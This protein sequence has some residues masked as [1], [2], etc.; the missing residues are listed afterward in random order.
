MPLAFGKLR[1]RASPGRTGKD[2]CRLVRNTIQADN[3]AEAPGRRG[4]VPRRTQSQVPVEIAAVATRRRHSDLLSATT[5][6]GDDV[7]KPRK[8]AR[9]TLGETVIGPAVRVADE[10]TADEGTGG[11]TQRRRSAVR[12]DVEALAEKVKN[13]K[14]AAIEQKETTATAASSR[15]SIAKNGSVSAVASQSETTDRGQAESEVRST[16]TR[17]SV[18]KKTTGAVMETESK[19]GSDEC[20]EER[21]S[22]TVAESESRSRSTR[23]RKSVNEETLPSTRERKTTSNGKQKTKEL[24]T[25]KRNESAPLSRTSKRMTE[26]KTIA[27]AHSTEQRLS[28][29]EV[30]D[31][32]PRSSRGRRSVVEKPVVAEKQAKDTRRTAGGRKSVA[33]EVTEPKKL[34]TISERESPVS[35]DVDRK[36]PKNRSSRTAVG[37]QSES[38]TRSTRRRKTVDVKPPTPAK[39]KDC[40][41]MPAGGTK[42]VVVD[43]SES[44]TRSKRK[45]SGR[46]NTRR[47]ALIVTDEN[48]SSGVGAPSNLAPSPKQKDNVGRPPKRRQSQAS[49][50][51][52]VVSCST[53]IAMNTGLNMA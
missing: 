23:N 28:L 42:E 2:T 4:R 9:L 41:T 46:A 5:T 25:E 26:K 34:Q 3:L 30:I 45:P 44:K 1:G 35:A 48:K 33:S 27:A 36:T 53:F 11:K 8:A 24:V 39:Q 12:T 38:D 43:D 15:N 51:S 7:S 20:I 18:V 17:R 10:S 21:L 13:A 52:E 50:A 40:E 22:A 37:S 47:S 49:S 29:V 32:K 31:N 6:A 19:D 16:R 14:V